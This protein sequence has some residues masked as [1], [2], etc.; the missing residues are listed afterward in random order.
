MVVTP[1]ETLYSM[2]NAPDPV[3]KSQAVPSL[4]VLMEVQGAKGEEFA[5]RTVYCADG[6]SVRSCERVDEPPTAGSK[7][8]R[9][10]AGVSI[11]ANPTFC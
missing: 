6:Q 3:Q 7:E 2:P 5:H 8:H 11:L 4:R 10:V 9:L 1:S